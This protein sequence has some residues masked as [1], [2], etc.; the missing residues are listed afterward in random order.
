MATTTAAYGGGQVTVTVTS[1]PEDTGGIALDTASST[2]SLIYIYSTSAA[3]LPTGSSS[4]SQSSTRVSGGVIAGIVVGAIAFLLVLSLALF[5]YSR[6]VARRKRAEMASLRPSQPGATPSRPHSHATTT[7]QS[8][9]HSQY[10]RSSGARSTGTAGTETLSKSLHSPSPMPSYPPPIAEL[11]TPHNAARIA[12]R[13]ASKAQR[14][15]SRPDVAEMYGSYT[16]PVELHG[17]AGGGTADRVP[18]RGMAETKRA[19]GASGGRRESRPNRD[20]DRDRRDSDAGSRGY[21]SPE[22]GWRH[23]LSAAG[24]GSSDGT[25]TE[26]GGTEYG[27]TATDG[28]SIHIYYRNS[29]ATIAQAM[30]QASLRSSTRGLPNKS[31][32]RSSS[33][34]LSSQTS[35]PETARSAR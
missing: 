22:P 24:P 20:R 17:G 23:S 21:L 18:S 16:H 30:S 12:A 5:C 27:G 33:I 8:N 6:K 26:Y 32:L 31:G 11:P 14:K 35:L 7:A 4:S 1:A 3:S 34:P 25:E 19:K 13:T 15:S 29:A 10:A 9:R 28:A 2:L